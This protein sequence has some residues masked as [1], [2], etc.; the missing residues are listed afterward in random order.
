M[1][2]KVFLPDRQLVKV[3]FRLLTNT[4]SSGIV[5]T[6]YWI[7]VI[8][9]I[10][11]HHS[12]F[13]SMQEKCIV[14]GYGKCHAIK[15]KKI[16]DSSGSEMCLRIHAPAELSACTYFSAF[17]YV[18][19]ASSSVSRN[20]SL[21]YMT[22]YGLHSEVVSCSIGSKYIYLQGPMICRITFDFGLFSKRFNEGFR[23]D[24]SMCERVLCLF[25]MNHSLP[26]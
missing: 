16:T 23:I 6:Q 15:G 12:S 24:M 13:W 25:D 1:E 9:C 3:Q 26:S 19:L 17:T 7:W 10:H 20:L 14:E 18:S 22:I 21:R 4:V 5:S 2:V 11:T 8:N